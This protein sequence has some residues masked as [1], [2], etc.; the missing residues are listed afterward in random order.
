MSQYGRSALLSAAP[1]QP[2]PQHPRRWRLSALLAIASVLATGLVAIAE[3]PASAVVPA[4]V[5]APVTKADVTERPDAL[6]AKLAAKAEGHQVEVTSQRDATTS[7]YAEPDGTFTAK[8]NQSPR[9]VQQPDGSWTPVDT[10]LKVGSDGRLHAANVPFDLSLSNGGANAAADVTPA[11][12]KRAK[13]V[14][15]GTLPTPVLSGNTARYVDVQPGI[16]LLASVTSSGFELSYVLTRRPAKGL[17]LSFPLQLTGLSTGT[18]SN[19]DPQLTAGGKAVVKGDGALMWDATTDPGKA[20]PDAL[21]PVPQ[22]IDAAGITLT[23]SDAFLQDPATQFPVTVDPFYGLT[24]HYGTYVYQGA[25]TTNYDSSSFL[26]TGLASTSGT[27]QRTLMRFLMPSSLTGTHIL[28][29]SLQMYLSTA[30]SCSAQTVVRTASAAFD[31][32]TVTW[33]TQPAFSGPYDAT[34]FGAGCTSKYQTIHM[35]DVVNTWINGG[36]TNN[37]FVLTGSP[38]TDSATNKV[39]YSENANGG[40]Q[41]PTLSISYN[42]YPGSPVGRSVRPCA[43]VCSSP[44]VTNSLTPQLS[45]GTNDADGGNLRYDFEVYA[46]NSSSPTTLAASGSVAGVPTGGT[47]YWNVPINKLT[48]PATYE[49][50][51]RAYDGVDYGPWSSGWIVFTTDTTAPTAP[52]V[53]SSTWPSSSWAA[54]GSSSGSIS[55]SDGDPSVSSYQ[56]W[57]DNNVDS[58]TSVAATSTSASLSG[59]ADGAHVFHLQAYDNAGNAGQSDYTFGIGNGVLASPPDGSVTQSQLTLTPT[60][61]SSGYGFASYQ[62]AWGTTGS[63]GGTW[64]TIPSG[65]LTNPA[66]GTHPSATGAGTYSIPTYPTLTWAAALDTGQDGALQVRACF[67]TSSISS[68]TVC[69]PVSNVTI[70]QQ[71]F[72]AGSATQQV[73]PGTLN[74][75]TGDYS[76][77]ATDA[78]L[79]GFGSGLTVSRTATT[80]APPVNTD[81]VAGAVA[82]AVG[83]GWTLSMPDPGAGRADQTLTDHSD[84][85]Y[86]TLTDAAGAV[87]TFTGPTTGPF[88]RSF[89]PQG[90]AADGT[91]MSVS[92]SGSAYTF[93]AT[94]PDGTTS[95]WTSLWSGSTPPAAPVRISGITLPGVGSPTYTYT[96]GQ[97]TSVTAPA[98]PGLSCTSSPLTTLGC[99]SL[100]FLYGAASNPSD[101]SLTEPTSP[102]TSYDAPASG[103]VNGLL[104]EIDAVVGD[105]STGSMKTIPIRRYG[106]DGTNPAAAHLTATWDPR[107]SPKLITSYGYG[108][109]GNSDRLATV[110]PPG[111]NPWMFGY[112]GNQLAYVKQHDDTPGTNA[113]AITEIAYNVPVAGAPATSVGLP[114]MS[115]N[116][117]SA[118]GEVSDPAASATAIFSPD[119]N[120]AGAGNIAAPTSSDWPYASIDYFDTNGRQVNT[121]SYGAGAWQID[122]SQYDAHGN[123]VFNLTADNRNQA[124]NPVAGTTDPAVAAIS[125]I[126][127]RVA[128]QTLATLSTYSSDGTDLVSTLGPTHPVMLAGALTPVD[129]RTHTTNMYDE[130]NPGGGPYHLV[131][132]STVAAQTLDLVDHDSHTTT[133]GYNPLVTGDG[134]GWTL[135]QPTSVTTSGTGGD[136][137]WTRFDTYGRTIETRL[138]A[139]TADA[140][141]AGNDPHS[142]VTSYYTASGSGSCVSTLFAGL[143]CTTKAFTLGI[144]GLTAKTVTGYNLWQ[145]PTSTEERDGSNTLL[146]TGTVT[147]DAAGRTA[148]SAIATTGSVRGGGTSTTAVPTVSYGYS[149]TTGLPTTVSDSHGTITTGYDSQGRT[150]SYT[151]ANGNA[152]STTYDID[153]RVHTRSDGKGTYTYSYD[154]T[155][156]GAVEHRGLVTTLDTGIT[157]AGYTTHTAYTASYDAAGRASIVTLP[158]GDTATSVF[159]NAGEQTELAYAGSGLGDGLNYAADYDSLGR[160][161][162]S[163]GEVSTQSYSYTLNGELTS[164][165]RNVAGACT[166]QSYGYDPN[167]N[168]TQYVTG[169]SCTAPSLSG[170]PAAHSYNAADQ[171]TDAGTSYDGLGRTYAVPATAVTGGAAMTV[172]Y[173]DNDMVQSQTQ[174]ASTQT[175]TLDA[176]G[177]RIVTQASG[178]TT[179]TNYYADSSDSPAWTGTSSTNWTRNIDGI[180]GLGAVETHT[181][182]TDT[183]TLQITDM[184]GDVV[185]TLDDTMGAT[186]AGLYDYDPF[187]A[188][189]G[190][191]SAPAKYGWLGG[192]QRPADDLGGLVLMGYRLYSPSIGRFLQT[193]PVPG[194]SANSY[195]YDAQDPLNQVDLDGRMLASNNGGECG[196]SCQAQIDQAKRDAKFRS[197]LRQWAYAL[198]KFAGYIGWAAFIPAVGTIAMVA[199]VASSVLYLIAGN[200][201]LSGGQIISTLAATFARRVPGA[202][203]FIAYLE[204]H[205]KLMAQ[206]FG[207]TGKW[208]LGILAGSPMCGLSPTCGPA[209]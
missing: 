174:G 179:S 112:T 104:A 26:R 197:Q 14:L 153:G 54:S 68:P 180:A 89:T 181:T 170:A 199:S 25:A 122:T 133:T 165:V 188:S 76:L 79:T 33:N 184:Q 95:T 106:Y 98:A 65:S 152:T 114:D 87:Q 120:P 109:G 145:Q 59:V 35:G 77:D 7:V 18:D 141:G 2:R 205:P 3:P 90:D 158:N 163:I 189:A 110:T 130:N 11:A 172:N 185:A 150:T 183:V 80:L 102:V 88:P 100:V 113:D 162:D 208:L 40:A 71:A 204:D 31:S 144:T 105:P 30:T 151:D 56:Y 20:T 96:G 70:E 129:A 43:A 29:A 15:P 116:T 190:A 53:S 9:N 140:T 139:G 154:Q 34:G 192:D 69:T 74:E 72:G 17:A 198:S 196:R 91:T 10:S 47:T 207:S 83:R 82:G 164:A 166:G 142:T 51:V 200:L 115:T 160:K 38:E 125:A 5:S 48:A 66:D 111:I 176:T 58:K 4:S 178:T 117:T 167:S 124:L 97:L 12:G 182:S 36:A 21:H 22:S 103:G 191:T 27:V 78:S 146:R 206:A 60:A 64:T 44:S 49:Y 81:P 147:Y 203:K 137:H 131:T 173:F 121:A 86:V 41:K 61:P 63:N 177:H 138:P 50:R 28:D 134:G 119:H 93:T 118:W 202:G 186:P 161:T 52:S 99:R 16:D 62:W 135:R 168:R 92:N 123:E 128:A 94:D 42:S 84:Q 136:T 193:D 159:D 46:G 156:N 73:G 39:W 24:F 209:S 201:K 127:T 175:F 13:W 1:R 148:T 6:S 45:G 157:A 75:I 108:G 101:P 126:S 55:W 194:G 132:T 149:S 143:P 57:L 19:G 37:G 169:S 195:D 85:G 23:P 171:I 107:I 187:G 32:S 8:L 67:A 155:V